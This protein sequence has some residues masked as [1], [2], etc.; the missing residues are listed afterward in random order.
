M[1]GHRI[2]DDLRWTII[3]MLSD[4]SLKSSDISA[5]TGISKREIQRIAREYRLEGTVSQIVVE[6]GPKAGRPLKLTT[7]NVKVSFIQS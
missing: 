3:R 5:Y 2:P 7:E 4:S 6:G 1:R